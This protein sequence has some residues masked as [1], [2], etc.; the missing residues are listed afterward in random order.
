MMSL[1]KE[2]EGY[3]LEMVGLVDGDGDVEADG[4][5]EVEILTRGIVPTFIYCLR[6]PSR[7]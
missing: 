5:V 7:S 2:D 4:V 3:V 1:R 6:Q